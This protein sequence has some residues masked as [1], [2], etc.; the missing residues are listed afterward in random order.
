[1]AGSQSGVDAQ[2]RR[3]EIQVE[4]AVDVR[5]DVIEPRVANQGRHLAQAVD[6]QNAFQVLGQVRFPVILR[7]FFRI[8]HAVVLVLADRWL[9]A[10]E[11]LELGDLD[12]SLGRTY[13]V[14]LSG[15]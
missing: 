12:L 11:K 15:H 2:F 4:L 9:A 3:S 14:P 7:I 6:D 13:P 10:G 5:R 1:M 8:K